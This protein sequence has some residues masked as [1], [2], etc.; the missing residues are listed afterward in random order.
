MTLTDAQ[1]AALTEAERIDLVHRLRAPRDPAQPPVIPT[2]LRV[3]RITR[4]WV[5]ITSTLVLIPWIAYLA[6]TLPPTYDAQHWR[7]TWVG[8]DVLLL[9]L[10]ATTVI[11]GLLRRQ[12]VVLT[13][14]A[15]GTLLVS[16]AWFDVMT[17][18]PTDRIGSILAALLVELPIAALLTFGTVRLLHFVNA[19]HLLGGDGQGRFVLDDNGG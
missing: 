14:F 13:A 4:L 16:D 19:H 15:T 9:A 11:L 6:I 18:S 7:V 17:A 8:L 3:A 1:I 10:T 5:M 2:R 12:L